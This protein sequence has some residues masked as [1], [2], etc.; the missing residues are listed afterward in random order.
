MTSVMQAACLVKLLPKQAQKVPHFAS[1]FEK[2]RHS[3]YTWV[4][5]I[6]VQ[7]LDSACVVHTI[8]VLF[9][10]ALT[11][12]NAHNQNKIKRNNYDV[13]C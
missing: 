9:L 4:L 13:I 5:L 1:F 12:M 7:L 11:I 2:E 6:K 10:F 8:P 3:Q